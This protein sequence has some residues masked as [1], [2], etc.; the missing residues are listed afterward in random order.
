[1]EGVVNGYNKEVIGRNKRLAYTLDNTL[2]HM[3][4]EGNSSRPRCRSLVQA[5]L[6][7]KKY[8]GIMKPCKQREKKEH[9]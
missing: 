9:P 5:S 8:G 4:K 2:S 7:S 6:S 3:L 1:V